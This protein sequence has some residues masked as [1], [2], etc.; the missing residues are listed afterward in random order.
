MTEASVILYSR[1]FVH[2]VVEKDIITT[3][4]QKRQSQGKFLIYISECEF[5]TMVSVSNYLRSGVCL[6]FVLCRDEHR[7]EA[8]RGETN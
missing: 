8:L 3:L 1:G 6:R 2:S 4:I 5:N 7:K